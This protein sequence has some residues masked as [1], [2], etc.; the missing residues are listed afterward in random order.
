MHT[1]TFRDD[2][3]RWLYAEDAKRS[4]VDVSIS[5]HQGPGRPS[6]APCIDYALR[7]S[8]SSL[9]PREPGSEDGV[10]KS[11]KVHA[12]LHF[13]RDRFY[14]GIRPE[15]GMSFMIGAPLY[16]IRHREF[17]LPLYA[18]A[19][20]AEMLVARYD[21]VLAPALDRKQLT[22]VLYLTMEP[23]L[24]EDEYDDHH[25][26]DRDRQAVYERASVMAS[27]IIDA[28]PDQGFAHLLAA[29]VDSFETTMPWPQ[30]EMAFQARGGR[31]SVT[32]HP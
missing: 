28:D 14:E 17:P 19:Y 15:T 29:H 20:N 32:V 27:A 12:W 8:K 23:F 11:Q 2:A 1:D 16:G 9:A 30:K 5:P 10:A 24:N 25:D 4:S 18:Y 6:Y 13:D 3:H 26:L 22:D 31:V 7:L 21:P